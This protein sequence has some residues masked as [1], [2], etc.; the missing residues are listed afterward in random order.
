MLVRGIV[1]VQQEFHGC[2]CILRCAN[3]HNGYAL[4]WAALRSLSDP[5]GQMPVDIEVTLVDKLATL[6]FDG[7]HALDLKIILKWVVK[8]T[9][10]IDRLY[11]EFSARL[12]PHDDQD[13]DYPVPGLP[14]TDSWN[15]L[16]ELVSGDYLRPFD[17]RFSS[18]SA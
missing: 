5:D 3:W 14:V 1:L 4:G 10:T 6:C 12:C 16:N 11:A 9:S 7:A 2:K 8:M 17:D 13:R 15:C 18:A